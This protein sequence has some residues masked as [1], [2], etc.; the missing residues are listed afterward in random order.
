MDLQFE[1]LEWSLKLPDGTV[2]DL[3]EPKG[4]DPTATA[5]IKSTMKV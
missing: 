4:P 2:V 3:M 1:T 5:E